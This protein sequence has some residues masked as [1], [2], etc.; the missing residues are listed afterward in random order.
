MTSGKGSEMIR[1]WPEGY[2]SSGSR[3]VMKAVPT[4]KVCF[5]HQFPAPRFDSVESVIDY[6]MPAGAHHDQES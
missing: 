5:E 3:W 1:D 2:C 6:R 4:P